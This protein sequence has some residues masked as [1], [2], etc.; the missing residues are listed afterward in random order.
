[1]AQQADLSALPPMLSGRNAL[2]VGVAN[3]RSID[4]VCQ[5]RTLDRDALARYFTTVTAAVVKCFE[6]RRAMPAAT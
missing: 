3:D 2:V 1:M 5:R 6:R 4:P